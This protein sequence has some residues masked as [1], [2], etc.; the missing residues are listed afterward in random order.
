MSDPK[1]VL[2]PNPGICWGQDWP[3]QKDPI[4]DM[5]DYGERKFREGKCDLV[6]FDCAPGEDQVIRAYMAKHHP[7]VNIAFGDPN[8]TLARS[9]AAWEQRQTTP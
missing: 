8:R 4:A 9:V 1:P 6:N 2:L 3:I 5:C 7:E